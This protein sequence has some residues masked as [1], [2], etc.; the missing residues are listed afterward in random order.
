MRFKARLSNVQLDSNL[1]LARLLLL[2]ISELPR[3]IFNLMADIPED[4]IQDSE[5]FRRRTK[6][7]IDAIQ[8]HLRTI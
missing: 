3:S 1:Q 4:N 5:W 8:T 2:P 6:G 7:S